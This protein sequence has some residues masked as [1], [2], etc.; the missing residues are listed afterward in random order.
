[1]I[2]KLKEN[3]AQTDATTVGTQK[4]QKIA[5]H[6]IPKQRTETQ[7]INPKGITH[8][9]AGRNG[10]NPH[11]AITEKQTTNTTGRTDKGHQQFAT[12]TR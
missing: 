5:E 6:T 12:L 10:A 9:D 2:S 1:M 11:L 3:T 8:V 7:L 4:E